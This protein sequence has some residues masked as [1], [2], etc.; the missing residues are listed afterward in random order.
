[1]SSELLVTL[2]PDE[3]R[4]LLAPKAPHET[5]S[6]RQVSIR[7]AA[8]TK[9][10]VALEQDAPHR[11]LAD[12][13]EDDRG[14]IQDLIDGPIDSVTRIVTREGAVRGNHFHEHT[15]QWTYVLSGCLHMFNGKV[16]R[17]LTS[18]EIMVHRPGEPHAWK[19]LEDTDCL[20]FTKG[21]RSGSEYESDTIRLADPLVA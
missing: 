3:V 11:V 14:K 13:F 7:R 6:H 15:T 4:D 16:D 5:L 21:P 19:A 2:T 20:V 12:S 17:L 9:L 1:M 18:G 10:R 8:R